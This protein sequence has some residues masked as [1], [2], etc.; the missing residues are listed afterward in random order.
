MRFLLCAAFMVTPCKAGKAKKS[1]RKPL[2][3]IRLP[4]KRIPEELESDE[5]EFEESEPEELESEVSLRM[6]PWNPIFVPKGT[7]YFDVTAPDRPKH[8]SLS[9]LID[10]AQN[11]PVVFGAHP[12]KYT[13]K[14]ERNTFK[15]VSYGD[16]PRFVT[17]R[18]REDGRD[19][20][21][22]VSERS[23]KP[24]VI[25]FF[26][27]AKTVDSA[28]DTKNVVTKSA[29]LVAGLV[30]EHQKKT[31][32]SLSDRF[33]MRSVCVPT[34]HGTYHAAMMKGYDD[35]T[36]QSIICVSQEHVDAGRAGYL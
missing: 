14:S 3:L 6:V 1:P 19:I 34:I 10:L 33:L 24:H 18:I 9:A 4:T 11:K 31:G 32:Y 35:A 25:E 22:I 7:R 20:V 5:S 28:K 2:D 26:D 12:K 17:R 21:A 23:K 27:W 30:R 16:F 15:G 13:F 8:N 36:P 29:C